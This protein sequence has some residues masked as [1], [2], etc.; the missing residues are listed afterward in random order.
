MEGSNSVTNCAVAQG[1]FRP[2]RCEAASLC[3]SRSST[4]VPPLPGD[5]GQPDFV[6][7]SLSAKSV[8]HRSCGGMG[9][10]KGAQRWPSLARSG[11]SVRCM[12]ATA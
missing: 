2:L 3:R 9:R 11:V 12:P 8:T 4:A 1:A 5:S 6:I 10:T 7:D